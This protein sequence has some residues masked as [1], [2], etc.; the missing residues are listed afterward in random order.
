MIARYSPLQRGRA[1]GELARWLGSNREECIPGVVTVAAITDDF[2]DQM[3]RQR[4]DDERIPPLLETRGLL[5]QAAMARS[6]IAWLERR[7][8]RLS[9]PDEAGLRR[10]LEKI[11]ALYRDAYHWAPPTIEI[12][13]RLAGKSVRQYVKSWITIW[14]I[15]RLYGETPVI[16]T[17][18]ITIDYAESTAVEDAV[19]RGSKD[20]AA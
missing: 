18:T 15:M 9:P 10:S 5:R 16:N 20:D 3:F 8:V 13:E 7:R 1:Y 14:D 6:G 19:E 2:P 17:E 11:G 4:H 12:G